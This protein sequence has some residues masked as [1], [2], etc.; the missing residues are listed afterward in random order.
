VGET[1]AREIGKRSKVEM[2]FCR[3]L[4]EGKTYSVNK[5][6]CQRTKDVL[7]NKLSTTLSSMLILK[8]LCSS[9]DVMVGRLL[10]EN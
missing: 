3:L 10:V 5:E 9:M 1:S 2:D 7:W 6:D 4:T 8:N